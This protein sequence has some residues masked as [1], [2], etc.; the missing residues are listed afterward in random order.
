MKDKSQDYDIIIVGAGLVGLSTSLLMSRKFENILLIDNKRE[1][2]F[3]SSPESEDLYQGVKSIALSLSSKKILEALDLWGNIKKDAAIIEKV[4]VS[5]KGDFG[6]VVLSA[7]EIGEEV[8][9]YNLANT[10]L[11]SSLYRKVKNTKINFQYD[12]NLEGISCKKD[13][14]EICF[15][16]NNKFER[17]TLSAELVIVT[18]GLNSESSDLLGIDSE[19]Q[20]PAQ[21]AIFTN[22]SLSKPHLNV[23]YQRFSKDGHMALLP[24]PASNDDYR[25]EFIW[26]LPKHLSDEYSELS[27]KEFLKVSQQVFGARAGIFKK[28]DKRLRFPIHR[29][30]ATEQIRHN[31]VIM[32]NS[33]HSIYPIA[34]Q[35]FNLSL[36]DAQK[37]SSVIINSR[38]YGKSI[39]SFEVLQDYL[40]EQTFDQNLTAGFGDSLKSAFE[41]DNPL[42][43]IVRSV[44]L[45]G[46]DSIP[47]LRRAVINFGIGVRGK[48]KPG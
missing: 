8:L 13:H 45:L 15:R 42:A 19:N 9:G 1:D 35:G 32:G 21:E 44:S 22:I 37:L 41:R 40:N 39:G 46:F 7:S 27:D 12:S 14:V 36:R 23:A 48:R 28:L 24:I 26:V 17:K 18:D 47:T 3:N 43:R 16:V 38:E 31:I 5:S 25:S 30:Q 33:A 20:S 10:I 2:S 29:Q 6:S 34:A 4:H 11:S